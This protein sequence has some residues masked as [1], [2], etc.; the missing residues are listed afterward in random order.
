MRLEDDAAHAALT[1]CAAQKLASTRMLE[2]GAY[3]M[4]ARCLSIIENQ[5]LAG[6]G[7]ALFDG[8]VRIALR[9]LF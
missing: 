7:E 1:L 3:S 6:N 4:N 5:R 8:E 2:R 9:F